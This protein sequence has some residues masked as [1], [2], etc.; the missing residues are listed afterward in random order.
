MNTYDIDE[1]IMAFF[2]GKTMPEDRKFLE[3]WIPS[4]PS[5]KRYFQKALNIHQGLHSVFH[6]GNINE[7]QSNKQ[8]FGYI[9]K[10]ICFRLSSCIGSV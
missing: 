6:P 8:I 4:D 3:T 10:N 1:L 2:S 5:H 9:N 7:E